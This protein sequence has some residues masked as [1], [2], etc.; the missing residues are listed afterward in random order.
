MGGIWSGGRFSGRMHL[1]QEKSRFPLN[2]MR[3]WI[4]TTARSAIGT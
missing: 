2:L 3:Y 1:M 4:Y